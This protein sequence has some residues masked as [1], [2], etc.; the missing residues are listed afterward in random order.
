MSTPMGPIEKLMPN[1]SKHVDQLKY[2]RAIGYLMYAMMSTRP[3]IAYAVGRLI[4]FT[5]NPSRHHW[6]AITKVFK[7][8]KVACEKAKRDLSSA[9]FAPIEI[10]CLHEGIDFSTKISRAKFEELNAT[11]FDKCILL[12]EECLRDGKMKKRDVDEVVLVGG[13]SRIPKVQRMVEEFFGGKTLC[14]SLN[15]DEAVA[16]GAAILAA[17]LSGNDDD[18]MK[19]KD[20]V[21]LDVTPLSLGIEV[22]SNG[23]PGKMHII[24]PKNTS[25]PT[26]KKKIFPLLVNETSVAILVY[27]GENTKVKDNIFLGKFDLHGLILGPDGRSKIEVCF[28]NGILLVYAEEISTGQGKSITVTKT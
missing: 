19:Q 16:S 2:S 13:S 20:V 7:Y 22:M 23:V 11:Y 26:S 27:Q 10:D 15:L 9:I 4:R 25:I 5:S 14:R 3:D 1:T 12:L 6:H 18:D 28:S 8:L 17:R 21:L 24:I